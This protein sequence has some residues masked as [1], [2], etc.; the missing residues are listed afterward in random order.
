MTDHAVIVLIGNL[1]AIIGAVLAIWWRLIQRIENGEQKLR[2]ALHESDGV[3]RKETQTLHQRVNNLSH[4]FR[5]E[6]TSLHK[7]IMEDFMPRRDAD[8]MT[9]QTARVVEKFESQ[10]SELTKAVTR[11]T[12]I[13]ERL[14]VRLQG[15]EDN[16]NNRE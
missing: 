11:L 9:K 2:D 6:C 15:I 3:L 4:D 12:V 8:A 7:T 14:E 1:V 13:V 5:Q 10:L 16:A